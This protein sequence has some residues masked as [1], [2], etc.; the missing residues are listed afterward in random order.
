MK[1]FAFIV[2]AILLLVGVS[3]FAF[4]HSTNPVRGSS[5]KVTTDDGI[6]TAILSYAA[7][8]MFV[9]GNLLEAVT[10]V[11][12]ELELLDLDTSKA[13]FSV[14]ISENWEWVRNQLTWRPDA[15]EMATLTGSSLQLGDILLHKSNVRFFRIDA[16]DF[17]IDPDTRTSFRF[18]RAN[19]EPTVREL[20]AFITNNVLMCG[21]E[22]FVAR[23]SGDQPV[24]QCNFGA[25]VTVPG[26]PSLTRFAKAIIGGEDNQDRVNQKLLDFVTNE[27]EY[28]YTEDDWS[29]FRQVVKR[30][31]E[32]LMTRKATCASKSALYASLLEQIGNDYVLVY[33][34]SHIAVFV[35]GQYADTNGYTIVHDGKRY[36]MAETT[37]PGFV[38][39]QTRLRTT[40]SP[41]INWTHLQRPGNKDVPVPKS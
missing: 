12:A 8:P 9:S 7:D 32:V 35:S 34:P 31:N 33:Y 5:A 4:T 1:K 3:W 10:G 36:Y 40:T 37:A 13:Y 21:K 41:E 39:G 20:A 23:Y 6:T 15:I 29:N 11:K 30:P 2:A 22:Y 28:D 26:E 19:Y 38:I 14:P 27:I 16:T 18:T 24:Y 25:R 17:K